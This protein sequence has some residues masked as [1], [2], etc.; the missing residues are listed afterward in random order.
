[1]ASLGAFRSS[2]SLPLQDLGTVPCPLCRLGQLQAVTLMEVL[3]CDGCQHLWQPDWGRQTVQLADSSQFAAWRWTGRHW[4]PSYRATMVLPQVVWLGSALLL[5]APT[6]LIALSTYL[7]PP[8]EPRSGLMWGTVW[9]T[10]TFVSH[11]LIVLW[12]LTAYY[13][14]FPW[15]TL[16]VGLRRLLG[17]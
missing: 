15:L 13:Q 10:L 17:R 12:V 2:P 16:Q 9:G 8:L 14:L 7:F 5:V 1:M 3:A 6:G 11:A 4:Q